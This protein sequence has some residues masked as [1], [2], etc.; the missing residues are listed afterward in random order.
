MLQILLWMLKCYLGDLLITL[1]VHVWV[2]N[3]PS[4]GLGHHCQLPL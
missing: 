4:A 3:L 1:C 2:P